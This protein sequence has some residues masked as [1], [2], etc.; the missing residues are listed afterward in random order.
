LSLSPLGYLRV[1]LWDGPLTRKLW[2]VHLLVA[3][4]FIPNPLNLPEVN[5]KG[6]KS[7]NRATKLEWRSKAG[8]G[9]D[10]A[11]RKQ[12]GDGVHLYKRSGMWRAIFYPEP[13]KQKH[14]GTYPTKK[15]ALEARDR[16]VEALTYI[17]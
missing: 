3:E 17:P 4:A 1:E 7:D 14:I 5:H 16:A 15:Q 6:E 12:R 13:G 2:F 8:H 9:R 10:I 11:K